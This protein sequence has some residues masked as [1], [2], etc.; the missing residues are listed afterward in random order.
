MAETDTIEADPN[1]AWRIRDAA[2]GLFLAPRFSSVGAARRWAQDAGRR[3]PTIMR[4]DDGGAYGWPI[5]PMMRWGYPQW[6]L[7]LLV[8][9]VLGVV[10]LGPFFAPDPPIRHACSP[11]VPA[12]AC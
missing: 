2:S 1:D 5:A 7:Y 8:V 11:E 12:W 6:T 9:M 10:T 3:R 4:P